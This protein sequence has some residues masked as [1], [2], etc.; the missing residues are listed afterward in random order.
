MRRKK[1]RKINKVWQKR[2]FNIYL[3]RLRAKWSDSPNLT[4]LIN[5]ANESGCSGSSSVIYQFFHSLSVISRY[6]SHDWSNTSPISQ[7]N[8][9][10][11]NSKQK[12]Q[13]SKTLIYHYY[14]CPHR[15]RSGHRCRLRLT[16]PPHP[17]PVS[18]HYRYHYNAVP[19]HFCFLVQD[20]G[21][22]NYFT[23][24][25][26]WNYFLCLSVPTVK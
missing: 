15:A 5:Y 21:H 4:T 9:R 10:Q 6:K 18:P 2:L 26:A 16:H 25:F 23:H 12:R 3:Y 1:R 17:L 19:H 22:S 7:M 11:L 14:H 24:F 8:Q 13:S 20:S